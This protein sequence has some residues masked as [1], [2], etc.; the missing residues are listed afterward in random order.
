MVGAR[1]RADH[2][3]MGGD[4]FWHRAVPGDDLHG[5][6][7]PGAAG[8]AWAGPGTPPEP[9]RALTERMMMLIPSAPAGTSVTSA[10][11]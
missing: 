3:P 6:S 11:S 4:F 7:P 8:Y 9:R 2:R 10:G 1:P 5:P